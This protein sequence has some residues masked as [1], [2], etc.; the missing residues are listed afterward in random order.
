VRIVR[1]GADGDGI[2]ALPDGTPLFV[3]LSA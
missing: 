2:A 1:G 3:P